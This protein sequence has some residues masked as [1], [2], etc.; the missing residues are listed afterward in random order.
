MLS[1]ARSHRA[2]EVL[3]EGLGKDR[4]DRPQPNHRDFWHPGAK[5]RSVVPEPHSDG[6]E[7]VDDGHDGRAKGPAHERE[8]RQHRDASGDDGTLRA[9]R[10]RARQRGR[11]GNGWQTREGVPVNVRRKRDLS[12]LRFACVRAR[13]GGANGNS[14]G[15]REHGEVRGV[16]CGE[17]RGE[18]KSGKRHGMWDIIT[19][20]IDDLFHMNGAK[21]R[22]SGVDRDWSSLANEKDVAKFGIDVCALKTRACSLARLVGEPFAPTKRRHTR[23]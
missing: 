1:L 5:S 23:E 18:T 17:L 14:Y 10:G 13:R 20:C 6:D 21:T 8:T 9:G 7:D 4:E 15:P 11:L 3:S 22:V 19:V 16:K 2:L 12:V